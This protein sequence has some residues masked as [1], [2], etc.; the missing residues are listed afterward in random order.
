MTPKYVSCKWFSKDESSSTF[1]SRKNKHTMAGVI[2]RV[3]ISKLH[4][5]LYG[6]RSGC[7]R[8]FMV[9]LAFAFMFPNAELALMF[10][11]VQLRQNISYPFSFSRFVFRSIGTIYFLVALHILLLTLE[12]LY[13]SNY[14]VLE[15]ESV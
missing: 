3:A 13:L 2:D 4:Q 14:V 1:K 12:V 7:V 9:L 8:L 15:E 11:P 10:I 5:C 6:N